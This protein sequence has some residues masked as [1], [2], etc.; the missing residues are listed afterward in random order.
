MPGIY[1]G[2]RLYIIV[3]VC[4][5]CSV[6]ALNYLLIA[7][8]TR[9]QRKTVNRLLSQLGRG[10]GSPEEFEAV[11]AFRQLGTNALP[12][13]VSIIRKRDSNLGPTFRRL[14]GDKLALKLG[15]EERRGERAQAVTAVWALGEIA[16]PA[17]PALSSC[18]YAGCNTDDATEALLGIGSKAVCRLTNIVSSPSAGVRIAVV[19]ELARYHFNYNA[20]RLELPE[21]SEQFI[22]SSKIVVPLLVRFTDDSEPAIRAIAARGLGDFHHHSLL[23]GSPDYSRIILPV[24]TKLLKDPKIEPRREAVNSLAG[25]KDDAKPAIPAL[26]EYLHQTNDLKDRTAATIAVWRIDR[27]A[28]ENAGFKIT[29]LPGN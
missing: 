18:V 13:L 6:I 28:A 7:R 19:D 16:A 25:L 24:L 23:G 8:G 26:L 11:R 29:E 12:Q 15:F 9:E 27:E 5:A 1:K 20:K 10:W 14:F 22:Q 3:G 2:K 17:I 21:G 4:L